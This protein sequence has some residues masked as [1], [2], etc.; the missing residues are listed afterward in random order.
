[1]Q[2]TTMHLYHVTS[3]D[4][5]KALWVTAPSPQRAHQRAARTFAPKGL[6]VG[7]VTERDDVVM[8][9]TLIRTKGFTKYEITK[10]AVTKG[11]VIGHL[12]AFQAVDRNGDIVKDG[13]N[14]WFEKL[15]SAAEAVGNL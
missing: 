12:G 7:R 9:R 3:N 14:E 5:G 2:D 4:P 1:M 11:Y 15:A 10:G 6:S 13:D 8:K